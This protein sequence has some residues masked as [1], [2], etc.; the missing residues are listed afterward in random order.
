[1]IEAFHSYGLKTVF[2]APELAFDS[3]ICLC[4][5]DAACAAHDRRQKAIDNA[6]KAIFGGAGP[7]AAEVTR[8]AIFV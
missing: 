3:W 8:F 2:T 1:M 5:A 6:T 7:T 4:G